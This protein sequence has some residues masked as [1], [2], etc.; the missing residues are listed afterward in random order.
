LSAFPVAR[1]ADGKSLPRAYVVR[2]RPPKGASF[3]LPSEEIVDS[4]KTDSLAPQLDEAA[5]A[6]LADPVTP[7]AEPEPAPGQTATSAPALSSGRYL[8]AAYTPELSLPPGFQ[9][10]PSHT[11]PTS[12]SGTSSL[13]ATPANR[14]STEPTKRRSLPDAWRLVS[15][16]GVPL[17]RGQIIG[18]LIAI[19]MIVISVSTV[20]TILVGRSVSA[21][22]SR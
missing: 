22:L 4:A 6:R 10:T 7:G 17:S 8:G 19:I 14:A 20:V 13:E 16:S 3:G 21:P 2:R 1:D 18:I 5:R 9:Q 12:T 11:F 15:R